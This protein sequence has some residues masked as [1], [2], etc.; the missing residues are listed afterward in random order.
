[1]TR[2]ELSR[3]RRYKHTLE[4]PFKCT[5]CE[6][7]SVEVSTALLNLLGGCEGFHVPMHF[8]VH[9]IF[10][11]ICNHEKSR[12]CWWPWTHWWI[13]FICFIATVLLQGGC[14]LQLHGVM[15]LI[16]YLISFVCTFFCP[17]HPAKKEQITWIPG[18]FTFDVVFAN[19][20]LQINIHTAI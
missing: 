16:S 20:L 12:L 5:I 1:M 15:H 8:N 19:V 13:V 18:N 2:G 9:T 3:H 14:W 10:G 17:H 7:S 11:Q 4:K 6:Y